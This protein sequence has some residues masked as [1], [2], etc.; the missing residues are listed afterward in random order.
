MIEAIENTNFTDNF[1]Y[2]EENFHSLENSRILISGAS[3]FVG[4]WISEL[5]FQISSE[6][7]L[8]FE[9]VMLTRDEASFRKKFSE[10]K[11]N[12]FSI[13]EADLSKE[14]INFGS[15]SHV[16]HAA[17]PTFAS[18]EVSGQVM[19]ASL[20]G[21]ENLINSLP[22]SSTLPIFINLSS[23]AVYGDN[24]LG[25]GPLKLS[26]QT[27]RSQNYEN[28]SSE[29]RAAKI[30]T[31]LLVDSET[32]AGKIIG[33]NPR[34]FAFFGPLLPVDQKYAIGN[35][36]LAAIN[37][38]SINLKSS[39]ESERSYLHASDLA[40]QIIY[41]LSNPIIG[42]SHIG[43]SKSM[44]LIR[45]A[46]Y[47]SEMFNCGPVV[48]G[49]FVEAHTYYV[50]EVDN[51]IPSLSLDDKRRDALFKDWFDWLKDRN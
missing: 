6:F 11:S 31:E 30:D 50:P 19:R 47:V 25:S 13:F 37:K 16:V 40:S 32:I 29:Y 1:K 18:G 44:S 41:L 28:F 7:D 10:S 24:L 51:R 39:G 23:G 12:A 9:V 20:N 8:K 2:F 5:L 48:K 26:A 33:C 43:S 36:M 22:E 46:E 21:A 45:W 35:F 4:N 17:T 3:G 14:K 34:L 42:P 27:Q 15:F 38:R 49:N